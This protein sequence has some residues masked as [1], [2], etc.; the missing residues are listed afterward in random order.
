MISKHTVHYDEV[1]V[2]CKRLQVSYFSRDVS[3]GAFNGV[4]DSSRELDFIIVKIRSMAGD[5]GCGGARAQ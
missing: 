1:D 4:A 3:E 2:A 5:G